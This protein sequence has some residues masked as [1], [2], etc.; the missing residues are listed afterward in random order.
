[1]SVSIFFQ[2]RQVVER[3]AYV[4]LG[5]PKHEIENLYKELE[6]N[7]KMI[8]AL[9]NQAEEENVTFPLKETVDTVVYEL[10]SA[11]KAHVDWQPSKV[12]VVLVLQYVRLDID[13]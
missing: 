9:V 12:F 11:S 3:L 10:K 7:E 2:T 6:D 4:G 5:I 13:M 8:T 1:M